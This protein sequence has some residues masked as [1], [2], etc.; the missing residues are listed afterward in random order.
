[1]QQK[2]TGKTSRM[3]KNKLTICSILPLCLWSPSVLQNLSLFLP[4]WFVSFS[5]I[6][7]K[8]VLRFLQCALCVIVPKPVGRPCSHATSNYNVPCQ[9]HISVK[10]MVPFTLTC[11]SNF[12]LLWPMSL[13]HT[14]TVCNSIPLVR[15]GLT[16]FRTKSSRTWL[17]R[18][19]KLTQVFCLV[20]VGPVHYFQSTISKCVPEYKYAT[21]WVSFEQRIDYFNY[22]P[23]L[24]HLPLSIGSNLL[25]LFYVIVSRQ[26]LGWIFS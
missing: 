10:T 12:H 25:N 20:N 14:T 19:R 11:E 6:L 22:T 21:Y 23:N 17:F 1:M 3:L 2:Q 5:A 26:Y 18:H 24:F 7:N 4:P 9:I 15:L 13:V 16:I 8:L